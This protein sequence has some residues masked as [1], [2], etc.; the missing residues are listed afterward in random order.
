MRARRAGNTARHI[1]ADASSTPAEEELNIQLPD[2]LTSPE[3]MWQPRAHGKTCPRSADQGKNLK[4][5]FHRL[6]DALNEDML[7]S[8][9]V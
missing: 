2:G 9:T 7:L 4:R 8:A 1:C 5:S 6:L 3:V